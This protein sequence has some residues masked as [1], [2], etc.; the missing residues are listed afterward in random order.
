MFNINYGTISYHFLKIDCH[1][2]VLKEKEGG[3]NF[4]EKDG[5][6]LPKNNL[7][8]HGQMKSLITLKEKHI[9]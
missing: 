2:K 6:T 9:G 7:N 5:D 4:S 1:F 8:L 3:F